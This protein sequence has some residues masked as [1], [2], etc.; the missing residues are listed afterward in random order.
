MSTT[1]K[2]VKV[3]GQQQ[4]VNV[5][6]GELETMNVTSIEDRDFNFHKVWMRNFLSTL[7][8]VGNHKTLL[9]MWIVD[10]I[11]R[12]NQLIGTMRVIANESGM[13]LETVRITLKILLDADFLRRVQSGVYI[14]N[15]EVIFKGSYSSRMNILNQ[16]STA[17][18]ITISDEEKLQNLLDSIDRLQ[19]QVDALRKNMENKKTQEQTSQISFDDIVMEEAV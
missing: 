5:N 1:V 19:K 15:P 2:K 12:D 4:Y 10:H 13:S 14:V 9:C 11:N 3:I 17:E 6:T 7:D 16:Y 18:R 8:I